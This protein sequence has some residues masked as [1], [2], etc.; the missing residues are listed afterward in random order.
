MQEEL[1]E[2]VISEGVTM[3]SRE[4]FDTILRYKNS[5]SKLKGDIVECGVWQG[6]MSI[7]LSKLFKEKN[8]WVCDSFEGCADPGSGKY[9]FDAESHGKG[10][11]A[12]SLETVK[13]NFT[14]YGALDEPRVSFLKGFVG[15]T[16]KPE[17]CPIKK[18]SLLRID[19]DSYSATLETLDY[20][21]P[22]V[23]SGGLVIFD[24]S[25]LIEGVTAIQT[26]AD[27]EKSIKFKHTVTGEDIDIAKDTLPCGCYFIKP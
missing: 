22:K 12:V 1:I 14:K 25:C 9:T 17:V 2:R 13:E 7:F 10:L 15:D 20:L 8:V 6:G 23:V 18:I 11:Y 19:V 24:D 21:Y 3:V 5:I 27:R 4:R 26:F 16:L